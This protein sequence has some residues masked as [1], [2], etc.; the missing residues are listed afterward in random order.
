MCRRQSQK[1]LTTAS[2]HGVRENRYDPASRRQS[3]VYRG[4]RSHVRGRPNRRRSLGRRRYPAMSNRPSPERLRP[5]PRPGPQPTF[6]VRSRRHVPYTTRVA[7]E[8]FCCGWRG[9]F[10]MEGPFPDRTCRVGCSPDGSGR[11]PEG[12]ASRYRAACP[13]GPLD[14]SPSPHRRW[15]RSLPGNRGRPGRGNRRS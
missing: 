13:N 15:R 8:F 3:W 2:R 10:L 11:H 9:R 12:F 4:R 7:G 5:R 1:A 6:R 14:G